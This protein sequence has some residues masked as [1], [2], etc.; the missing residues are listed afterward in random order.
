[1]LL[2]HLCL[3]AIAV[4]PTSVVARS[5]S[6]LEHVFSPTHVL[7]HEKDETT[8]RAAVKHEKTL[9]ND[10]V[11]SMHVACTP[12]A[13]VRS[14]E[15]SLKTA[16]GD[17]AVHPVYFSR[18]NDKTC[19]TFHASPSTVTALSKEGVKS[20]V[21]PHALKID[22]S[23]AWTSDQIQTEK[24][25]ARYTVE[26][27]V[28]VGVLG[29][30]LQSPAQNKATSHEAVWSDVTSQL[31]AFQQHRSLHSR[32]VDDFFWT[33]SKHGMKTSR[34]DR[35]LTEITVDDVLASPAAAFDVTSSRFNRALSMSCDFSGADVTY[36]QSHVSVSM[37]TSVHSS[38]CML[39]L[40]S[41]ASLNP[42]VSHISAFSSERK[43][44]T[45]EIKAIDADDVFANTTQNATDQNAWTQTGDGLTTPY[46]DIGLDGT[47]QVLGMI[48]TGVD[49]YSCFFV[50]DSGS[51]TTR[52][53]AADYG[54]PIT[55]PERRKVIQYVAWADTL[56]AY[57]YDHGTWCAGSALGKCNFTGTVA[58][59]YDGL[60]HNAK[61]AVFD[62]DA[63]DNFLNVPD[64]YNIALPPA[65]SA[66]AKVSTNSWGT[67]GMNTY[68][69]KALD[70]DQYMNE[71]TDFLF[72]VAAGNDGRT[73]FTS[74][75][76]PGVSKN[77][78]TVG[79]SDYDHTQLIYFSSIGY[80][81]DQHMFKPNIVTPG[82]NLMSAG[83]RNTNETFTCNVQ[84]SSGTSMATPIAAGA[85]ILVRQYFENATFWGSFC[86]N[87]YRSCPKVQDGADSISGALVKAILTHSGEALLRTTTTST[88][89]LPA[90]NLSSTPDRYQG[91]GQVKLDNVLP[92]PGVV[93]FELYVADMEPLNSLTQRKYVASVLEAGN[94]FRATIV[95]IDPVNVMWSSKNL[96]NDL[97]L[98]V[99]SPSGVIYYGNNI[100]ADE[101]NPV[102][103]VYVESA[104]AGDWT[105]VVVAHELAVGTSQ[106]YSVVITLSGEVEESATNVDPVPAEAMYLNTNLDELQCL[107]NGADYSLQRFQLEDWLTG[108]SWTGVPFNIFDNGTIAYSCNFVPNSVTDNSEDNRVYQCAACL[109]DGSYIVSVD[110]SAAVNGTGKYMRVS[111]P[112]NDIFLS[113]HQPEAVMDLLDG[114]CNLCPIGSTELLVTMFANV[115]DDDSADYTW[116]GD[117][118]YTIYNIY[119]IPVHMGTLMVSDEQADRYCM[120][121]GTY[122]F[123]LNDTAL[124]QNRNKH[125][126]VTFSYV[127]DGGEVVSIELT[128]TETVANVDVDVD[129]GSDDDDSK[130]YEIA[131]IVVAVVLAVVLIVYGGCVWKQKRDNAKKREDDLSAG[132]VDVA[133][134]STA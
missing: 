6:D 98:I 125:A 46:S 131:G 95:W 50:D 32:H 97:D 72:V 106:D 126:A 122:T 8:L 56:P 1:M 101:F 129:S 34:G 119:D 42:H 53:A 62:V 59:E 104:E 127:T 58:T 41:V 18:L 28:G 67:P 85:A 133:A 15:T 113:S 44:E 73:G 115:T 118:Y 43:L 91:W 14:L 55:E 37:D 75:H 45:Q 108:D 109:R 61:L 94:P 80:N 68:T 120:H 27:G 40:A 74:V 103:R 51:P 123:A 111:S 30:G 64:L 114:G 12:Y 26:I 9:S 29:K 121:E 116:Y 24:V 16:V 25:P 49:D 81:Y 124:N 10:D 11:L 4:I 54:T 63:Q 112:C 31:L 47:N 79:A 78:L 82:T 90:V 22:S 117:A 2:F 130:W 48:D 66:G 3:T 76:S 70:V 100:T 19:Y 88:S 69:S 84:V 92:I 17:S 36:L 52:T 39:L 93:D 86:N 23:V 71:N 60:A 13:S 87:D 7:F 57:N 89:V 102:E 5:H 20:S 132:L 21:V 110:T 77:A 134:D 105:I 65:Y 35:A 128:G 38:D 33:S 96:L 99:T 107:A 83:T